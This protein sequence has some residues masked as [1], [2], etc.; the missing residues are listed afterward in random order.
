MMLACG[1]ALICFFV[2][3]ALFTFTAVYSFCVDVYRTGEGGG[4]RG[5][6]GGDLNLTFAE[7]KDYN[8][9]AVPVEPG[10]PPAAF[11]S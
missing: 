7:D 1:L 9:Q 5:G 2:F 4:P 11:L 6:G 3:L 8:N 10:H